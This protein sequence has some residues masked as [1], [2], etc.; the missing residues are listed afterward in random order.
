VDE[1]FTGSLRDQ[2]ANRPVVQIEGTASDPFRTNVN[3]LLLN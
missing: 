3:P 1:I 2:L